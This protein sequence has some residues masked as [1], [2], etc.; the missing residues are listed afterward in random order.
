MIATLSVAL[1][2]SD[3]YSR[4]RARLL[5]RLASVVGR[6]SGVN[7]TFTRSF[8]RALMFRY[9]RVTSKALYPFASCSSA[10]YCRKVRTPKLTSGKFDD[11]DASAPRCCSGSGST[12]GRS[13]AEAVGAG[14][15]DGAGSGAGAAAALTGAGSGAG[16]TAA[17]RADAG[18]DAAVFAVAGVE[19]VVVPAF[20]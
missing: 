15:G 11:P 17:T 14:A 2:S 20:A 18:A 19:L 3:A 9:P 13:R 10:W 16:A 5:F 1:T 8:R 6:T 12:L 7:R 4:R